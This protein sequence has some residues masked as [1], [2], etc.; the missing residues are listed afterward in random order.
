VLS[1][2]ATL[3]A[4]GLAIGCAPA[5]GQ[6]AAQAA[7]QAA[8]RVEIVSPRDGEIVDGPNVVV[9]LAA[10]DFQV[11]PAGNPAPNSG[12][13][14]VFLDRDLSPAG[15]PIPAN[16]PGRLVHMGNGA[17]QL[18]LENVPSGRHRLI[19]MV[20]DAGHVP[21]QPLLVDTVR[22]SVR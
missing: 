6:S 9:I 15:Q 13:H 12:H 20:G 22:F 11:V 17:T 14:H 21:L 7:P 19:A 16:E 8:R 2:A 1:L 5:P 4:L 3:L 18:T 10:H